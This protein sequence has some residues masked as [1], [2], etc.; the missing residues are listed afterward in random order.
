MNG[1]L[2][3]AYLRLGQPIAVHLAVDSDKV[4]DNIFK[5][6]GIFILFTLIMFIVGKVGDIIIYSR[7]ESKIDKK[8][9]KEIYVRSY[10]YKDRSNHIFMVGDD[11]INVGFTDGGNKDLKSI[12]FWLRFGDNTKQEETLPANHRL[13]QRLLRTIEK[14]EFDRW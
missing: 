1:C 11:G 12:T 5:W 14:N 8:G 4:I 3:G 2:M 6:G 7:L 13:T 9:L 10:N